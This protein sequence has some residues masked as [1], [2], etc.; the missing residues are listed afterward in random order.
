[1]GVHRMVRGLFQGRYRK[2]HEG[3]CAILRG[4]QTS[5]GVTSLIFRV[6]GAWAYRLVS[7]ASML[8]ARDGCGDPRTVVERA[9]GLGESRLLLQ[10][11]D[12]CGDARS[13]MSCE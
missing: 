12:D 6:Q 7:R 1:M 2:R 5:F 3:L 9:N 13:A 4:R 11:C 10:V 8:L